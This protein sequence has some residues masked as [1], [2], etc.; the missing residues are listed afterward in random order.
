[1]YIIG[2]FLIIEYVFIVTDIFNSEIKTL[3]LYLVLTT[4]RTNH[5]LLC[6]AQFTPFHY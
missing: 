6:S 2:F 4:C 1:M 3:C 5:T